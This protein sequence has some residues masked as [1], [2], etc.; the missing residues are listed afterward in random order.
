MGIGTTIATA[1][2]TAATGGL[3]PLV[4]AAIIGIAALIS[5]IVVYWKELDAGVKSLTGNFF[6]M[7]D[8]LLLLGVVVLGPISWLALIGKK[9]Y[10][11]WA[12]I[13]GMFKSVGNSIIDMVNSVLPYIN[14]MLSML[15]YIPGIDIGPITPI[16]AMANG[17]VLKS[18]SA[19]VGEDR[20][21]E[22]IKHTSRG[23]VVT[24]LGPAT[25][26]GAGGSPG[27]IASGMSA[28][29]GVGKP[30]G[31]KFD[32]SLTAAVKEN[33]EIMKKILDK[34]AAKRNDQPVELVVNMGTQQLRAAG[35]MI[36]GMLADL[37]GNNIKL[38]YGVS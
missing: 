9:I 34:P 27:D 31:Q 5:V 38:R 24:P 37:P 1:F 26:H 36:D 30:V 17:G 15:S 13:K 12:A 28:A 10:D 16:A 22:M 23:T 20:K 7:W 11:N 32:E 35:K 18:G 14:K 21:P 25:S 19:I 29:S 33:T 4:Y 6:D 3:G 2:W 8:V